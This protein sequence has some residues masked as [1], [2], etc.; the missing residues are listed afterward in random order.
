[1]F[2]LIDDCGTQLAEIERWNSDPEAPDVAEQAEAN[3]QLIRTAPDMLSALE[4]AL[5]AL[6]EA[7]RFRIRGLA[8][9]SYGIASRCTRVIARAKGKTFPPLP[10]HL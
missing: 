6:N 10:D 8:L 4:L 1:M 2:S 7:P 9:D 5:E 3:A